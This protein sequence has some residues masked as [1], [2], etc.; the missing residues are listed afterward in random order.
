MPRPGEDRSDVGA[1]AHFNNI[2][3]VPLSPLP[4]ADSTWRHRMTMRSS[5]TLDKPVR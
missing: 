5:F 2:V 4:Y 3:P 1:A